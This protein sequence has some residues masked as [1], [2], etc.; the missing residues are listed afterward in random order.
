[1]CGLGIGPTPD[2]FSAHY[3]LV[4]AKRRPTPQP[5]GP[6]PMFPSFPEFCW[7]AYLEI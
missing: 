1:M 2:D 7:P 3:D 5:A 4:Q 6:S